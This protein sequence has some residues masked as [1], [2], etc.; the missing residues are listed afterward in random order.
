MRPQGMRDNLVKASLV[1]TSI[2]QSDSQ[3]LFS[4][5]SLMRTR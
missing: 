4:T 3:I 5:P 2:D 1:A